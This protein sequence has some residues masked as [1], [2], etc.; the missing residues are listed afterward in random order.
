MA[1]EAR[2]VVT[3]ASEAFKKGDRVV[4]TPERFDPFFG[5]V[6]E[7]TFLDERGVYLS[8][9]VVQRDE[10]DERGRKWPNL[11]S[12]VVVPR[13]YCVKRESEEEIAVAFAAMEAAGRW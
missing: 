11:S 2:A 3:A 7:E 13:R 5:V 12:V 6:V 10:P 9:V 8:Y 1:W 4:A